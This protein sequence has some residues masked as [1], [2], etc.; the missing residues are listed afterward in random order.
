MQKLDKNI[1]ADIIIS[2]YCSEKNWTQSK[3]AI[4]IDVN[5]SSIS[6]WIKG[7][8][9]I[10]S[11][12]FN[13]LLSFLEKETKRKDD[14]NSFCNYLLKSLEDKNYDIT[15]CSS[16]L[17]SSDS[18]SSRIIELIDLYDIIVPK[19]QSMLNVYSIISRVKKICNS[20]K[21]FFG[22]SERIINGGSNNPLIKN[23]VDKNTNIVEQKNYLVLNFPHSYGVL[24]IFTNIL[25]GNNLVEFGSF[26]KLIKEKNNIDLI[27]VITDNEVQFDVQRFCLENYNLFF[28]TITN[29]ELEKTKISNINTSYLK[30]RKNVVI[31]SYAQI[32]F[33]RFSA[34]F[35]VIKNEIIFKEY[36]IKRKSITTLNLKAE[37]D[38]TKAFVDKILLKDI[39]DYSYLSRHS[40]YFE[41]NRLK[42][43]VQKMVK[44]RK[45]SLNLVVELCY[46]NAFIS[47][48]IIDM[49]DKMMLFT[50]SIQAIN[51]FNKINDEY[52]KKIIHKNIQLELVHM[53]PKYIS[54]I[55]GN[56]IIG[57]VDLV[58][59]GFGMGSSIINITE[60]LRYINSWLSPNGCIF[61]SFV[62]E[63]SVLLQ[64]Q[65]DMYK[66]IETSPLI[67]SDFGRHTILENTDLLIKLKRY[68]L[69]EVR[70]LISTYS[71]SLKYYTYPYLS[72]L[73]T[74]IE[75]KG[76]LVDEIREI[77]KSY[78]LSN[79]CKHGHYITII[80]SKGEVEQEN[81]INQKE[82]II[83]RKIYD[84]LSMKKIDF[85]VITHSVAIDAKGLL[86]NLLEVGEDINE[87]D[88]IKTLVLKIKNLDKTY[89]PLFVIALGEKEVVFNNKICLVLEKKITNLFGQGCISPLVILPSIKK[90]DDFGKRYVGIEL[91]SLKK[92][93]VIFSSGLNTESIKMKRNIFIRILEELNV[94]FLE[95]I[96]DLHNI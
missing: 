81:T 79:K 41:R 39:F 54:N 75:N 80:G 85:E 36:E 63:D 31:F 13:A 59:L 27:I 32:V 7:K 60:Y 47:S 2:Y 4:Q 91:D 34:Y 90:D 95:N 66:K 3:I 72:G 56:D 17:D 18:L 30:D 55:Y 38:R 35:S 1:L 77:D 22:V 73:V 74:D 15:R 92:E 12:Y 14:E 89:T 51:V 45:N 87:F 6:N 70:T 52:D 61:I 43:K 69:D 62:N 58:V 20:Y 49:C 29:R 9:R 42:V 44:E 48:E 93:Y 57:K 23:L 5:H 71:D 84:Y 16:I 82:N 25:F 21:N 83:R 46:P 40:I 64:K 96:T 78:A 68:S 37:D 53:Y 26:V 50:S 11:R 8:S 86:I 88:L 67:F 10:S 76:Y 24:L 33:D 65:Y 28:E 19:M 94:E